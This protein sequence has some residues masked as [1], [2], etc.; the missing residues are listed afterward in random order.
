MPKPLTYRRLL[1]RDYGDQPTYSRADQ[2]EPPG[3]EER[4]RKLMEKVRRE[5]PAGGRAE[6]ARRRKR[7]KANHKRRAG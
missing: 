6:V 3:H 5:E 2:Q 4:I 1:P 7:S